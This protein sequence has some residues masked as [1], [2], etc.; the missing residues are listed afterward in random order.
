MRKKNSRHYLIFGFITAALLILAIYI[1]IGGRQQRAIRGCWVVEQEGALRG[2]QCGQN[3]IAASIKDSK[4]QYNRWELHHG[5]LILHGKLFDDYRVS[6]FHDTLQ[7]KSLTDDQLV[8]TQ[9][10]RQ[11]IYKKIR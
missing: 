8:V 9:H 7:I 3:G 4:R 10:G 5:E 6:E 11:T 1:A 2:F